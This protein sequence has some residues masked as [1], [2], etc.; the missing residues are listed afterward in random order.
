MDSLVVTECDKDDKE[1]IEDKEASA[2]AGCGLVHDKEVIETKRRV[3]GL[4]VGW[5]IW[6]GGRQEGR[7][8]VTV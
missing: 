7:L 4:D 1:A 8:F 5:V 2:R 6:R 3:R